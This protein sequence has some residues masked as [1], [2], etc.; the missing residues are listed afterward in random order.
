M[1]VRI[2][3][4]IEIAGPEGSWEV[5]G[6]RRK[7][8]LAA[9]AVEPGRVVSTERLAAAVWDGQAPTT[10][11]NTLQAHISYLRRAFGDPDA[12]RA[13]SPGYLLRLGVEATDA[14]AAGRLLQEAAQEEDPA[15]RTACAQEAV[16]L[17]R[18]PALAD[19]ADLAAFHGWAQRLD[20]LRVRARR[21]LIDCLLTMGRV[22]QAVQD[23]QE[24]WYENR[25]DE[26]SAGLLMLALYQAGRQVDAL[27]VYREISCGLREEL[28]LDPG[29]ALRELEAAILRQD[30]GV[31]RRQLV[32]EAVPE[33]VP[34]SEPS[35]DREPERA[36]LL[37]P[38]QLPGSVYIVGRDPQ[39][40]TLDVLVERVMD[41]D[42]SSPAVIAA[43][44]GTAGIGKTALAVHWARGVA[45]AFPDGQLHVD[46]HGSGLGATAVD[47]GQTL[48]SFLVALGVPGE[49]IPSD[50][51][52]CAAL[53]RSVLA[54]RR[55]LI[56]LDNV[57]DAEQIRP[58]LPGAPG[59][60][61]LVTSRNPLA[62]LVACEGATAIPLDLLSP[63]EA[64][65]LLERRLGSARLAAEPGP[66][67][68]VIENCEGLPLA[69]SLAGAWAATHPWLSIAEYAVDLG[70]VATTFEAL[71]GGDHRT[72]L[73]AVFS[74]SYCALSDEAARLLRFQSLRPGP[75][76]SVS[77]AA[78]LAAVS[79]DRA[80][81]LVVELTG[82]ALLTQYA[83]GRYGAHDLLCRFAYQE[84][85][86][87]D[88]REVRSEAVLRLME[89]Y[90][91]SAVAAARW[92]DPCGG[93]AL[94]PAPR[95]GVEPECFASREAAAA[96]LRAERAELVATVEQAVEDGID[97]GAWSLVSAWIPGLRE[98]LDV[99]AAA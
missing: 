61:V 41:A 94:L 7:A 4:P 82:T 32:P 46:L 68:G 48:R 17:W 37:A 54:D 9:L 24:L 12:I 31:L 30:A 18:G 20:E 70:K 74:W 75:G 43:I 63:E 19:V 21:L 60:L 47:T 34:V 89:Y 67:R 15:R 45:G 35:P 97:T 25:L 78:S 55:V 91:Y 84:S 90:L 96:W 42:S 22:D 6:L 40:G 26:E 86:A 16:A 5:S 57:R 52:A 99:E 95:P 1:Q 73:R 92:L 72:D 87:H 83:P 8:V 79:R 49:R 2:L 62:S 93:E 50:A 36:S 85:M 11:R 69:I 29:P 33:P 38:A 56:V 3:G 71:D 81:E 28:G 88:P 64:Q 98:L 23:A 80:A 44:T 59:C 66:F 27:A 58:L 53:F 65:A 14:E 76:I 39:I 77:A 51:A 13:V 10:V